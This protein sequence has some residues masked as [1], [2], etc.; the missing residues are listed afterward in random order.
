MYAHKLCMYDY[1]LC[2]YAHK[3]C[4]YDYKLCMNV[5]MVISPCMYATKRISVCMYVRI[6]ISIEITSRSKMFWVRINTIRMW[7][8]VMRGF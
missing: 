2:M 7:T 1:Q 6:I 8:Y 4:M 3:L 5:C